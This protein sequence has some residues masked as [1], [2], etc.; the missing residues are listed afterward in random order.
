MDYKLAYSDNMFFDLLTDNLIED[1]GHTNPLF[2]DKA[3]HTINRSAVIAI[4]PSQLKL[5]LDEGT[6]PE[7]QTS[8]RG[9]F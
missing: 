3:L 7:L 2:R 9:I 1:A 6:I 4:S 8:T 5:S